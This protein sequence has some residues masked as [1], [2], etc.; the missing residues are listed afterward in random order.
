MT[1]KIRSIHGTSSAWIDHISQ[2]GFLFEPECSMKKGRPCKRRPF[3]IHLRWSALGFY[4]LNQIAR[5][6][7]ARNESAPITDIIIALAQIRLRQV[8]RLQSLISTSVRLHIC[9]EY[10]NKIRPI[11]SCNT[12]PSQ[13]YLRLVYLAN[14]WIFLRKE[15]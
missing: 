1:L 4:L 13:N 12:I 8:L 11:D 9:C 3:L 10:P 7:G 15:K 6:L 14:P 2:T 5:T